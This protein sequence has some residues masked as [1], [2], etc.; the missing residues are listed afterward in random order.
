MSANII[1][2]SDPLGDSKSV[3]LVI[4][5]RQVY[6]KLGFWVQRSGGVC[7]CHDSYS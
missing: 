6:S 1:Q 2:E 7:W 3:F 4:G 5:V